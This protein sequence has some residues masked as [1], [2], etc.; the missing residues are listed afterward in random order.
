MRN[1]Q[2]IAFLW[3]QTY[4][5]IFKSALVKLWLSNIFYEKWQ[6]IVL[7]DNDGRF[8]ECFQ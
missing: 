6:D 3:K 7:N 1:F 2:G 8:S 5:E 4:G